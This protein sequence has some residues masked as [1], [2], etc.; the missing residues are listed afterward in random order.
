[1]ATVRIF[2]SYLKTPFLFLL[3]G[4][5]VI[6]FASV[7]SAT[8]LRFLEDFSLFLQY[9]DEL[10]IHAAIIAT[11]TPIAMLAT[12]LYQ[13]QI[14]EGMSGVMIRILISFVASSIIAS[15]I[16]YMTPN[17]VLG[18]G[19]MALAFL[20]S[21]FIIGTIRAVFF[22]TVDSELFK[23]RVLVYG[24]GNTAAHIERRMRRKSDRRGF[25]I[26]GYVSIENQ[27]QQVDDD[28]LLDVG[29]SLLEY[30]RK[31]Q[32]DEIVVATS[33]TRGEI[34]VDALVECK[35]NGVAVLD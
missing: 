22:E 8:Y 30:T 13:G 7:Y 24:A 15:L 21:F 31:N 34:P 19:I 4:E 26:I 2:Q 20:Q 32:V 29:D 35:L 9:F 28:K 11:I 10:W 27:E 12:G 3:C 25:S 17:L 33:D 23:K 1:M 14:R 6:L 16:Y 18:R 5:V